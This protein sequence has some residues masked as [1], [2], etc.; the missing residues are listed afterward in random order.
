MHYDLPNRTLL[1]LEWNFRAC[2][3]DVRDAET[4]G[5]GRRCA[6]I[7]KQTHRYAIGRPWDVA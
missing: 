6:I 2:F 4:K 7:N 5:A 3:I 1:R